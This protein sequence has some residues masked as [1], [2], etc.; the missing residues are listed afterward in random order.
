MGSDRTQMDSGL[1]RGDTPVARTRLGGSGIAI[2]DL[3]PCHRRSVSFVILRYCEYHSTMSEYGI[4][5]LDE[6]R[7]A[8]HTIE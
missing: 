3:E 8:V 6:R 2:T 5:P 4:L 7:K 1:G